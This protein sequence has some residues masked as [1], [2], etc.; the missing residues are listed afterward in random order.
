M[1]TI[2]NIL[3]RITLMYY[4]RWFKCIIYRK[5]HELDD[6]M[7]L[8][9]GEYRKRKRGHGKRHRGSVLGHKVYDQSREEGA[10]KLYRDYFDENPTYSEKVFRRRFRMSS[11][12]LNRV[13]KAVEEHDQSFV[14]KLNAAGVRGF[15][16]LQ[17]VTAALRQ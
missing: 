10:I 4:R 12:L 15:S 13:A 17:K 11:R 16:Y 1:S 8:V 7:L 2:I 14:Q 3:F 5:D 9:M 6:L